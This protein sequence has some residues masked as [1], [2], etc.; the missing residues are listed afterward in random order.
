MKKN[1][2][3]KLMAAAILLVTAVSPSWADYTITKS[4]GDPAVAGTDRWAVDDGTDYV[5][6]SSCIYLKTSGLVLSGEINVAVYPYVDNCTLTLKDVTI[7][8]S[9][10]AGALCYQNNNEL[11]LV[12]E[13][14][15]RLI[16]TSGGSAIRLYNSGTN[17]TF[18][19]SGE[20]YMT[21]Q[22][23]NQEVG[24]SCLFIDLYTNKTGSAT[25]EGFTIKG[26]TANAAD[27]SSLTDAVIDTYEYSN[28]YGDKYKAVGILIGD[29]VCNTVWMKGPEAG[30]DLDPDTEY[31][32]VTYKE[33]SDT[34]KAY[35]KTSDV[36]KIEWLKGEDITE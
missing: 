28:S 19:G 18:T 11:T 17:I 31:V 22:A 21:S 12:L 1:F 10:W 4:N 20:L 30:P 33:G 32:V 27:I 8:S 36:E 23:I 6:E 25:A 16:C 34:K 26:S 14:T 2:T 13:G 29:A 24:Q 5:V 15:N 7:T 35:Y 3:K 9:Y